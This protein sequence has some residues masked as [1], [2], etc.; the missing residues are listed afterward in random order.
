VIILEQHIFLE[1]QEE[2]F[3]RQKPRSGRDLQVSVSALQFIL[4]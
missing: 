1:E 2:F 4:K 3:L